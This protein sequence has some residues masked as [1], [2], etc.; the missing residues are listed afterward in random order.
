MM[1]KLTDSQLILLSR[2][3]QRD[4][5]VLEDAGSMNPGAA[6]K[7]AGALI[8]KKLMREIRSKPGMPDWRQDEDGRCWSL[9]ITRAGC[10]VIGVKDGPAGKNA[11]SAG[12]QPAAS[13]KNKDLNQH[14]ANAVAEEIAAREADPA[15]IPDQGKSN[16]TADEGDS[17]ASST[18]KTPLRP[19]SK[20][21]AIVE[22]MRQEDGASMGA[23]IAA[24]GWLPHT[25]RAALTGLRKRG[26]AIEKR[27]R[28]GVGTVYRIGDHDGLQPGA[29]PPIAASAALAAM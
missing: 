9:V 11:V 6:A 5:G 26:F 2:A 16:G 23:M 14:P 25:T 1:T 7:V 21:A 15:D 18:A 24:T 20:L 27:Q 17:A 22:L 10:K 19:S 4:D 13:H 12:D 28:D 3:S 8:R 29:A